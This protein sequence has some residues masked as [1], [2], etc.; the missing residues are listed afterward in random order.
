MEMQSFLKNS[1]PSGLANVSFLRT[2]KKTVWK[3]MQS[4]GKHLAP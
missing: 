4:L 2:Y 3:F 1:I